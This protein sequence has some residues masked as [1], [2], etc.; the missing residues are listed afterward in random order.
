MRPLLPQGMSRS[1]GISALKAGTQAISTDYGTL[2][3]N[4]DG[5]WTY[6]VNSGSELVQQLDPEHPHFET[7]E[8]TVVDEHGAYDTR[9]IVIKVEGSSA[10][11]VITDKDDLVFKEEERLP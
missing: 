4:P 2:T 9:E 8:I 5:S 10:F 7:F 3:V 11:P 6:V 1:R